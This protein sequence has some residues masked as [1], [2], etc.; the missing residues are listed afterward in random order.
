[1]QGEHA[2]GKTAPSTPEKLP[3]AQGTHAV[4]VG[5]PVP[6]WYVPARQNWQ[7]PEWIA[8]LEVENVPAGQV[9]QE[10]PD[11]RPVPVRYV[12]A[13]HARQVLETVAATTVE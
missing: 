3:A 13:A 9:V 4:V 8:P 6:V 7:A 2:L 11:A 12:P 10:A 5:M 1:M